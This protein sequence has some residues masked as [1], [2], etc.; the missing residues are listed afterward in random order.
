MIFV[1][2]E[3]AVTSKNGLLT[4]MACSLP[5]EPPHYALEGSIFIGGASI[6]WLRDKL[7]LITDANETEAICEQTPPLKNLYVVPA[8]AGLGAP[9]WDHEAKGAI[10]G[11]TLDMGKNEIVKATVEAL[12]LQTKD[13]LNAM[14]E[15][16]GSKLQRLQVDGGASANNYLM[17]FQADMLNVPVDRPKMLEVTALGAAFLAGLEAGI[18]ELSE[19]KSIRETECLF[20]PKM[21]ETVR[22]EKY[23]GWLD[24]IERTKSDHE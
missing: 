6:Q 3:E 20:E 11:L 16:C 4:T 8:F 5:E 12:A 22:E 14:Q 17:Q 18:W 2:G 13:V 1:P 15:D 7:Q 9:Y 21:D 24:A 10:Y 23:N 19:L